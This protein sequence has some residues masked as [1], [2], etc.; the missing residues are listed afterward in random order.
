MTRRELAERVGVTPDEFKYHL[1]EP[2]VDHGP[3]Q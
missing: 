1:R 2:P 3:N